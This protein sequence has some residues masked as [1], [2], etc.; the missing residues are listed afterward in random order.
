MAAPEVNN[1]DSPDET[2]PFEGKGEAYPAAKSEPPS[3]KAARRHRRRR[4]NGTDSGE[5]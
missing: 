5:H 2:R 4:R 1:F 3:R